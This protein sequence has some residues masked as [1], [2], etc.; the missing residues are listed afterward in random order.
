[1]NA[2]L[3]RLEELERHTEWH[4]AFSE[5]QRV[6]GWCIATGQCT[7]AEGAGHLQ[8]MKAAVP[9]KLFVAGHWTPPVFDFE[10]KAYTTEMMEAFHAWE[11]SQGIA[12]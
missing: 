9:L 7:E 2:T 8:R 5:I 12:P 4:D 6:I 3:R 11:Q 1:M 10:H